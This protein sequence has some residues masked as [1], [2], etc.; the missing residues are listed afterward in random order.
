MVEP[1]KR[2]P[3]RFR[4]LPSASDTGVRAGTCF[5]LRRRLC[6]GCPP[7]FEERAGVADRR[8]DLETVAH[9][10][11]G[12]QQLP[13]LACAEARDL[14]GIESGERPAIVVPL[15]EDRR[16]GQ[17]GL[18]AFEDQELE[19]PP[20]VV[21]R[22]PPFLVVVAEIALAAQAPWA[23]AFGGRF[24]HRRMIPPCS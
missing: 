22:H 9:D 6:S 16:P 3:R 2:K 7:D 8:F 4:S 23:A 1:T 15:V 5:M 14:F 13:D 11:G 20:I 17:A 12:G 10:P 18:G 24:A 21:D 19:Q